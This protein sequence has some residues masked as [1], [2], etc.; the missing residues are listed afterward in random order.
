[1][2]GERMTLSTHDEGNIYTDPDI[3]GVMVS[4]P[5]INDDGERLFEYWS[6]DDANTFVGYF[7]WR[8]PLPPVGWYR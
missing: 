1:M 3:D 8:T 2:V 4:M 5:W 6:G 7:V